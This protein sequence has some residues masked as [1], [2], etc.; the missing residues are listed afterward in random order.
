MISVII[1]DIS[2]SH[3]CCISG[4]TAASTIDVRGGTR[5]LIGIRLLSGL[6]MASDERLATKQIAGDR[7]RTCS[8]A[9]SIRAIIGAVK[10]ANKV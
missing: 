9:T 8:I 7:I 2:G 10:G 1:V 5:I 4:V 3:T 6:L